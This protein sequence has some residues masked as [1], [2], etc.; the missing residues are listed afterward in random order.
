[1]NCYTSLKCLLS[2]GTR[3]MKTANVDLM[4]SSSQTCTK[5]D[6]LPLCPTAAK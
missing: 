6:H 5:R 4:A 3:M 2:K 1:M